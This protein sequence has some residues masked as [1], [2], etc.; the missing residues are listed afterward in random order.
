MNVS[1]FYGGNVLVVEVEPLVTSMVVAV[2][3]VMP[4]PDRAVV[5]N[6]AAQIVQGP[7]VRVGNFNADV[8][9]RFDASVCLQEAAPIEW[10]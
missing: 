10:T 1:R 4:R 9:A 6:D 5:A 8:P 7:A 3:G 2:R